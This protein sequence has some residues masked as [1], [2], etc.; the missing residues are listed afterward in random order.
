MTTI[1]HIR[2]GEIPQT[3]PRRFLGRQDLPLT[4]HGREQITRLAASPGGE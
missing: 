2:H 3:R 4:D 1:Y